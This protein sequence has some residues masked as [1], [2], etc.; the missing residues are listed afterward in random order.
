MTFQQ[1]SLVLW[2]AI[3]SVAVCNSNAQL[4]P[5]SG[6]LPRSEDQHQTI[7]GATA[8]L[9]SNAALYDDQKISVRALA[10][11]IAPLCRAQFMAQNEALVSSGT[12]SAKRLLRDELQDAELAI[13]FERRSRQE[14][15]PPQ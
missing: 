4:M 13:L 6:S 14:K 1:K 8:C 12:Y 7:T 2:A 5:E 10:K 15:T 3:F 11:L 9:R